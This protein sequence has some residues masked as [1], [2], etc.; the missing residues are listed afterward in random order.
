[1]PRSRSHPAYHRHS[2]QTLAM[3]LATLAAGPAPAQSNVTIYGVADVEIDNVRVTGT[4]AAPATGRSLSRATSSSSLIG[5]RGS[6]EL[7]NGLSAMFQ[8]ESGI[9]FDTGAQ[10]SSTALW[11]RDTYV[12]L[13]SVDFGQVRVGLLS[14]PYRVAE[15]RFDFNPGAT[16]IAFNAAL[17]SFFGATATDFGFGR[18]LSN[19]V[20]Y[21][22]PKLAGFVA[23]AIWSAN[24]SAAGVPN[25]GATGAGLRYDEGPW[26]IAW[27]WERRNGTGGVGRHDTGQRAGASYK[28]ASWRVGAQVDHQTRVNDDGTD[29]SRNA[30]SVMTG[31]NLGR[32]EV[33]TEFSE[34]GNLSGSLCGARCDE[35]GARMLSLAYY[36]PLSPRT[37][38]TFRSARIWNEDRASYE[39]HP[40]A[41]S[42][43]GIAPGAQV[44]AYAIGL[45]H[46]F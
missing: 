35:T 29:G 23:S 19:A 16:G 7:G 42:L 5:F 3:A 22:T 2:L 25:S 39:L 33:V 15:G 32:G 31:V 38:L 14:G 12:G 28:T 34:A 41:P 18:R 13:R 40:S 17:L 20:F 11:N 6:E 10:T 30:F 36:Y 21:E 24:E 1:M 27:T 45:R 9:Q 26:L 46:T 4:A 37:L 8:L 43:I 44:G